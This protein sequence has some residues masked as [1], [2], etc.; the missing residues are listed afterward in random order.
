[1]IRLCFPLVRTVT[2]QCDSNKANSFS[3][4]LSEHAVY[5]VP[6]NYHTYST[7]TMGTTGL[8]PDVRLTIA[9]HVDKVN[10]HSKFCHRATYEGRGWLHKQSRYG[11]QT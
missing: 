1:M 2:Y 10:F 8:R 7:S 4:R 9:I 11:C 6:R 3:S 5:A